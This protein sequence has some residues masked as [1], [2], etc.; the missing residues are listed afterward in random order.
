MSIRQAS[1]DNINPHVDYIVSLHDNWPGNTMDEQ[2]AFVFMTLVPN[3]V[4]YLFLS[5]LILHDA[6]AL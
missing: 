5:L 1:L 2:M 6:Y 4:S 3:L